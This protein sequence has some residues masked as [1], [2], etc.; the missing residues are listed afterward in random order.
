DRP[1]EAICE[2]LMPVE[3]V[4]PYSRGDLMNRVHELG[5][6]NTEEYTDKGTFIQ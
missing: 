4:V 6:C 5:A 2:L 1:Q 3:A